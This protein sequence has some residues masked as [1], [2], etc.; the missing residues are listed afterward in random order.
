MSYRKVKSKISFKNEVFKHGKD[1]VAKLV[2]RGKTLCL[3]LDLDPANYQDS[4]YKIEDISGVSSGAMVPTMYR[5]T[6]PR[7]AQYAKELILDLM[8]KQQAERMDINF[9]N[10]SKQYPYEDDEILI[11]KGLIRKN[12][13]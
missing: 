2:F 5:I 11:E 13:K 6:L 12:L 7:R 8:K 10:Y 3:Y 4:K 1:V 9:V